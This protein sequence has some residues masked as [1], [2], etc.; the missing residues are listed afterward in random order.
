MKAH[1]MFRDQDFTASA[2]RNAAKPFGAD[3]LERDLDLPRIYE[4]MAQGDQFL[5][6]VAQQAI[7]NSLTDAGE[8]E[9]RQQVLADC[10]ASPE[11]ARELY[12]LAVEAIEREHKV[13]LGFMSKSPATLL[14]RSIDVLSMFVEV[15][16][17]LR[18]L[19]DAQA[20][21]VTSEGLTTL[22][23]T[24]ADQL[25]DEYFAEI[26]AHLR[27]LRFRHG[28]TMS[29]QLGEG[30]RGTD[31]VLRDT[32]VRRR[33]LADLIHHTSKFSFTI[34]DRDEAGYR[35]LSELSDRGL[36]LVAD[37]AAR[38]ADHILSFFAALRREIGFYVAC[39]NM[40]DTLAGAGCSVV[41]PAALPQ[42]GTPDATVLHASNLYDIALALA[43]GAPVVGNDVAADGRSLVVVTGANQGG[44]STFL[45]STGLAFVLM[46]AG[47][48]VAATDFAAS[49]TT[50]IFTHFKREEDQ[51]MRS[52]KL[53]EELARMS[54]IA[55]AIRPGGI[56]ISN[57]SF[58]STNER[59]GSEIARRILQALTDTN[60]RVLFVTHLYDLAEGLS[61]Q[62]RDDI[63]FLRAERESDGHRSFRV[64]PGEPLPTSFGPDVYA[65]IFAD[66]GAVPSPDRADGVDPALLSNAVR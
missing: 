12:A 50:G 13:F 66:P 26:Q 34:P 29:A 42:A 48:N 1:L 45:R 10:L 51:T 28:M 7:L 41:R 58:A 14:H 36:N 44:K 49:V 24:L 62:Q 63:L 20:E 6:Q 27:T 37:A 35:A 33:T 2:E 60:V 39:L 52:G 5:H 30:V 16:H 57:E 59:E 38:S 32:V 25:S 47:M 40:Y 4:A 11:M 55:D 9:Y 19:A 64:V 46:Q 23:A 31:Y 21:R 3:D 22:F 53:D 56:L 43:K 61:R 54:A 18:T 17:R 8:I 15:L 65:R